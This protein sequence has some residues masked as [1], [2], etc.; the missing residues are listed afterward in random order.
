MCVSLFSLVKCLYR[1]GLIWGLTVKK[2]LFLDAR[3]AVRSLL[4]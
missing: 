3:V 2:S 1:K 4:S